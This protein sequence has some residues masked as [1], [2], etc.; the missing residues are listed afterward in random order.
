MEQIRIEVQAAEKAV[1]SALQTGAVEDWRAA[2]RLIEKARSSV[3]GW[4]VRSADLM[5]VRSL[6]VEHLDALDREL[7]AV[8]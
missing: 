3:N 4:K 6:V 7:A 5:F 2:V 8:E 1:T